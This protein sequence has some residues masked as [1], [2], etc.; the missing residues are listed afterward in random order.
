MKAGTFVMTT[1]LALGMAAGGTYLV[2]PEVYE[3]ILPD[4]MIGKKSTKKTKKKGKNKKKAQGAEVVNAGSVAE[5]APE[6]APEPEV[7]QEE[8]EEVEEEVV[9]EVADS[10]PAARANQSIVAGSGWED[11]QAIKKQLSAEILKNAAGKSKADLQKFFRKPENMMMLAQWV[12]AD[13]ELRGLEDVEK[14]R[15]SRADQLDKARKEL[16]DMEASLPKDADVPAAAAW[17]LKQ[18]RTRVSRLEQE[19][20]CGHS[21]SESA[22]DEAGSKL[23]EI[24]AD[25]PE[26]MNEFAFSGECVR[27]GM[28]LSILKQIHQ[29]HP[30]ML[31]QDMVRKIATATALEYAKSGWNQQDAVERASFYIKAWKQDRLNTVFDDLPM[32]ERRMVCGC[33]GDNPYGSLSS[34]QW[35]LENAHIPSNQ[36]TGACWRCDYRLNNIYGDSIHGPLYY[37]PFETAMGDNRAQMTHYVGGVCGSLSHFGA[38][39]AL[40]N[41]VPAMTAGEPGHCAFIVKVGDKWTPAYSLSWERG[42]HWQVFRSVHRYSSLHAASELYSAEQEK[43][44]RNSNIW[45]VL[46]GVQADSGDLSSAVESYEKAAEAQPRNW[47]VWRE[48]HELLEKS[49]ASTVEQWNKLNNTLCSGLV[50]LYPELAYDFMAKGLANGMARKLGND[51]GKLHKAFL[52]FWKSVDAMG[53]DR[54]NIEDLAGKQAAALGVEKDTEKLCQFYADVLGATVGNSKYAPAVL[55]WGNKLSAKM[56]EKGAA[57]LMKATIKGIGSGADNMAPEERIKLLSSP[58]LAAEKSRDISAFNAIAKM[59]KATGHKNPDIKMPP[60]EPFSGKLASEKGLVWT[61]STSQWDKPH[62]HPGLLTPEGGTFH[63]AKDTDAFLAVELPR[64]VYVTGVVVVGTPGN[65]HRCNN[66]KVQVSENGTDWKDV[67]DFG[68]CKQRVMRSD[69][70]GKRPVAKYVRILRAGGPEF[71]HLNG[72]YI[73]GEQA[74]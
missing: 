21:F 3:G 19:S 68:P 37:A 7:K 15:K 57:A 33:K 13:A 65:L 72:I 71:F 74:A 8:P 35:L 24:I 60:F 46:A 22:A 45:R 44:T 69:L 5:P 1:L 23:M 64:Q 36:Y 38:F 47:M 14:A 39:A 58:L 25:T 20:K 29:K 31:K 32:W 62:E 51:P 42:L 43:K 70:G 67:H 61:S 27:P 50:P 55:N 30:K 59:V 53:P 56:D 12:V 28:A 11:C 2:K 10:E 26:W 18:L 66:M 4:S 40:A 9:D 63:T 34:L 54:W 17:K 52:K 6:V 49:E 41:G 73:Y 16:A 48:W